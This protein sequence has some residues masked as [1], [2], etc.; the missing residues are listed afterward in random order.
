MYATTMQHPISEKAA[1]A[2]RGEFLPQRGKPVL[3]AGEAA[4]EK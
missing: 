2:L 3:L 1:R 4:E